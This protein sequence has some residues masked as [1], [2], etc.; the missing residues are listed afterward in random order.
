MDVL[1]LQRLLN[2]ESQPIQLDLN[3][4]LID[5]SK[6]IEKEP[7]LHSINGVSVF[8]K[9][10]I[11]SVTGKAKSRKSF[12]VTA[13]A[14]AM[15][16]GEC[17]GLTSEGGRVLF[18]DTEQSL[19]HVQRAA[20]RILRLS[21]LDPDKNTPELKV[22]ALRPLSVKEKIE[23]LKITVELHKP[24]FV[25]IDGIVDMLLN[26]NDISESSELVGLLMKLSA[27]YSCHIQCVIHQNKADSNM[28]GHS[29][30]FLIQKSET[31]LE[32]STIDNISTVKAIASRGL[33]PDD[34]SFRIDEDGLPVLCN[35]PTKT[36]ENLDK[37][38]DCMKRSLGQSAMS[39]SKLVSEYVAYSGNSDRTAKR[40]IAD[41]LSSGFISKDE[42][43]LYRMTTGTIDDEDLPE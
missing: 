10:N 6:S 18:L 33:P 16:S 34:I 39:Y 35:Q 4:Y 8:T 37:N 40:H 14:A 12:F 38:K 26:F 17:L 20:K 31:I 42:Q 21:G 41:L 22:Y 5:V 24:T 30:S 11:S 28:R 2:K 36:N 7:T 32:V 3:S 9:G 29:G 13:V 1:E 19:F 15:I 25:I 43:N 27:E 23:A